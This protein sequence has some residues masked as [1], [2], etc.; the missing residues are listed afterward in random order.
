MHRGLG[1][2]RRGADN[3]ERAL[4]A[5]LKEDARVAFAGLLCAYVQ[6]LLFC[7]CAAGSAGSL[8][9]RAHVCG[10][11]RDVQSVLIDAL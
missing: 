1:T 8:A 2:W 5:S 11:P 9:T 6:S 10:L 7:K 4:R 3:S